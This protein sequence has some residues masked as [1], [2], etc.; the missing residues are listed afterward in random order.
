MTEELRKRAENKRQERV[1]DS[2]GMEFGDRIDGER[3]SILEDIAHRLC[4]ED[5]MKEMRRCEKDIR[6]VPDIGREIEADGMLTM[7]QT[8]DRHLSQLEVK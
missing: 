1:S 6:S 3:E 5:A 7:I 8:L 4:V 2:R